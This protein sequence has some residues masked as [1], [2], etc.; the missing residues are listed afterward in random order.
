[1]G[2]KLKAKRKPPSETGRWEVGE[3]VES[4]KDIFL[5]DLDSYRKWKMDAAKNGRTPLEIADEYERLG[6]RTYALELR[7][8]IEKMEAAL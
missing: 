5:C 3:I 1:M 6:M 4:E 8:V 7:K 2:R